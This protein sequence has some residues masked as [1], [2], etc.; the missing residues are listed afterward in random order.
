MINA[1][2]ENMV[3]T[4]NP[5]MQVILLYEKAIACLEEAREIME[6]GL[7]DSDSIKSKYES[8]GRATEI[9]TVLKATLNMEQGGE[10]AKNLSE[11]YQAL[12]NDL[13]RITVEGDDPE[14]IRKMV[15]VLKE[16]KESWE[17][18]ERKIYGKPQETTPAV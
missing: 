11:I 17:A 1:Y 7:Q 5:V 9:L 14:T 6:K 4:A 15:K 18:V 10:I 12:L 3:L 8:L 16:L 13:V 2:L